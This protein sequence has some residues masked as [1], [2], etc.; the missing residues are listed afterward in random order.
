MDRAVLGPVLAEIGNGV[1]SPLFKRSLRTFD[2]RLVSPRPAALLFVGGAQASYKSTPYQTTRKNAGTPNSTIVKKNATA[3]SSPTA[4]P[5]SRT[6]RRRRRWSRWVTRSSSRT[7]RRA[8]AP[9]PTACRPTARPAPTPTSSVSDRR[10]STSGSTRVACP[11]RTRA[12]SKRNRRVAATHAR[13]GARGLGVGELARRRAYPLI[14]YPHLKNA[15]VADGAALFALNCAA[16]HTIEG[17]GDALAMS[18]FSPSLRKIP[19]IEVAEAIR[20]GPGN[21]PRFTGQPQR[22]PG[23]RH[24]EVR[25]DRDPAP[26]QPRR[27]RTRWARTG[28]RR[29]RR[30]GL[31]RRRPGALRILGG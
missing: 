22:R 15:N 7:A 17:D 11:P 26:Q 18:T 2:R 28:R 16:C 23:E 25:D 21:M 31:R 12:R 27:L 1:T 10:R 8:T 3:S 9:R 4:T 29:I 20:T 5:R 30:P 24:R 19:S 13:P 6:A 14:P